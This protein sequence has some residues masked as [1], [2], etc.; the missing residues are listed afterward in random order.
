MATPTSR[1]LDGL[2]L[3]WGSADWTGS[4]VAPPGETQVGS[5]RTSDW[6]VDG[7]LF[8]DGLF[9]DAVDENRYLFH[10]PSLHVFVL[11]CSRYLCPCMMN[12]ANKE[13][14]ARCLWRSVASST[15][16]LIVLFF[17]LIGETYVL[18]EL[19]QRGV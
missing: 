4:R 12:G 19:I 15:C 6:D 10:E 17:N 14:R 18:N 1:G 13:Q 9:H 16:L 5:R 8:F 2:M 11:L 7:S 3:L